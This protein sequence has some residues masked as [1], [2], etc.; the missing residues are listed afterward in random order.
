MTFEEMRQQ[1]EEKEIISAYRCLNA[2][3]KFLLLNVARSLAHDEC[4]SLYTPKDVK[5]SVAEGKA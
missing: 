2:G 1:K 5:K 4:A 3:G